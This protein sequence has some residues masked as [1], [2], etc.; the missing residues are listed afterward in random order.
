MVRGRRRHPPY[1]QHNDHSSPPAFHPCSGSGLIAHAHTVPGSWV[2]NRSNALEASLGVDRR[3][4]PQS[5]RNKN[6]MF[7][8]S[9]ERKV[10]VTHNQQGVQATSLCLSLHLAQSTDGC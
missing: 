3:D 5:M 8:V 4:H 10:S 2:H 9:G 6:S 1:H 7:S